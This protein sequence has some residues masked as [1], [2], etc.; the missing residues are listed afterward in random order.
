MPRI[1]AAERSLNLNSGVIA[2]PEP[3]EDLN[4]DEAKVWRHIV[5]RMPAD[6]FPPETHVLLL[7][8]CK[9]V[10]GLPYMDKIIEEA[11]KANNRV[12][13]KQLI[14]LRRLECKSI[15]ML[16]TKMRLAQQSSYNMRNAAVVKNKALK[17]TIKDVHTW[18]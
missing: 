6:W 5:R 13:W 10:A 9:Q 1:S 16:A 15:A 11:R 12:E 7:M 17:E 18:S 3:H 4:E 14:S 2:R 8:Y